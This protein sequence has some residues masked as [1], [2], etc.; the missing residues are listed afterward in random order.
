MEHLKVKVNA[1][2]ATS[3]YKYKNL[4]Q[5]LLKCNANIHFNKQCL[6]QKVIPTYAKLRIPYTSPASITTQRKTQ[7]IRI[8]DE[9]R[10]LHQKKKLD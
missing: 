6:G 5:K 3:I 4:R 10:F 9:I 1:S 2:Q 7:L 8:K